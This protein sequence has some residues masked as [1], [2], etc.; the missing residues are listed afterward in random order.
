MKLLRLCIVLALLTC[1]GC[2]NERCTDSQRHALYEYTDQM[3][4]RW[5]SFE[6]KTGEKGKGGMENDGAK[7]HA[8][9]HIPAG[10]SITLLDMDGPGIINRMWITINRRD[11][12]MLRS[13]VFEIYWDGEEKP[14]VSVP[15]GDFFGVNH[16]E[17][18]S[19]ENELFANPE[20]RSFNCF[21]P[22]PFKDHAKIVVT[23]QTDRDMEMI[24]YDMN[25]QVLREWNED[26]LYFHAC[27]H[28][29]TATILG[30]DF[31]VL[32]RIRGKGR[33]LGSNI[34]VFYNKIY[35]PHWWGE[36]EVKV[37]LDGDDRFPTL[38]GSGTEDYI[39]SAW[40]QGE[41]VM[42]QS[43]C[44]VLDQ[45][46]TS[47]YR[48]HVKDPVYFKQDCR[49]TIQQIGCAPLDA[50]RSLQEAG[51]PL[52]PTLL[53]LPPEITHLYDQDPTARHGLDGFEKG[54]VHFY[55]SDDV[56]ATAY[57]YLDRPVNDLPP[58]QSKDIRLCKVRG[59]S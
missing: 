44:L 14:A 54:T 6:N 46:K 21:I 25:I 1:W 52:I 33:F 16:G 9:D 55:R 12:E 22:M 26:Y 56:A 28:R 8:C 11:P 10:A 18:A 50:V 34:G 3:E 5:V 36:G 19:F 58:L 23:N 57:F 47:F 13:L 53:H 30:T 15:F 4:P 32:P 43:G 2:M 24:F 29:D 27:W 40:G 48:Y 17:T 31:E 38:V 51:V 45:D 42:R 20:G 35:H 7:G 49:V 59:R 41:F 37:Y 39:G